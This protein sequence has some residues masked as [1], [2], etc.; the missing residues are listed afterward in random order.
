MVAAGE[1]RELGELAWSW[2]LSQVRD[3]DGPWLPEVVT[4][5]GSPVEPAA[6]R[7]CLYAGIAGLAPVLAEVG[8]H[9]PLSDAEASLA[10]GIV[11][12][13]TRMAAIRTDA[14]LY[15][16]LAGDLTALRLLAPGHDRVVLRRVA[17]LRTP[18][19]WDAEKTDGPYHDVISGTAGVM[20][21]AS[22][23]GGDD[24]A[25]IMS[26]GGDALLRAAEPTE[27]GLDWR[28][29]ADVEEVAAV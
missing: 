24:A 28:M 18:A 8:Q 15:D 29:R 19:G 12:R 25:E 2:V 14:S 17:E 21:A 3:D 7:D 9:R 27:G 26:T 11:T 5:D 16:G 4:D 10:T 22:W 13:L 23:A 20:L 6:D 1:Y